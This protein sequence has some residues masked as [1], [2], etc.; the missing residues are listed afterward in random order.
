[1]NPLVSVLMPVYQ[2]ERFLR[3]AVDSV[4]AQT[5][6]EFELVII[7]DGSTD[8]SVEIAAEYERADSRVRLI[9][10]AHVGLSRILNVGLGLCLGSWVARMDADDVCCPDRL[11]AQ[12]Q[13]TVEHPAAVLVGTYAKYIGENGRIVGSYRLG[14]ST[15]QE[16]REMMDRGEIVHFI[17]PTVMMK[18]ALVIEAGGYDPRFGIADD[19]ELYNRL[20]AK[21]HLC[22]ALPDAK[23]LYRVHSKSSVMSSNLRMFEQFRFVEAVLSA[24]KRGAPEPTYAEF[25]DSLRARPWTKRCF[26]KCGDIGAVFYRKAGVEIGR[27]RR[28]C[29]ALWLGG[30]FALAPSYV[31]TKLRTQVL[32]KGW[33][34]D[35]GAR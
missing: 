29:G 15:E 28:W 7:D 1:M 13:F 35:P 8:R 5:F 9:R 23:L 33:Q 34:R 11:Q 19:L 18:R 17:H 16:L 24:R 6:E 31:W 27:G 3:E 14:P 30:A 32:R 10:H 4:L 2:G 26:G 22:L 20:L 25:A 12:L 21:G